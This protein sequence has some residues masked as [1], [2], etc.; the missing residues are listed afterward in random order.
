MAVEVNGMPQEKIKSYKS[1]ISSQTVCHFNQ[2]HAYVFIWLVHGKFA[3][4][5]RHPDRPLAWYKPI[6]GVYLSRAPGRLHFI[7]WRI[8]KSA[9]LLQ[10]LSPLHKRSV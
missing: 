5:K 1:L 4:S 9:K 3:I 6:T 2:F 7:Q 10:F 8:T